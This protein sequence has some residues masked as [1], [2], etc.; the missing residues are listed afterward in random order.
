MSEPLPLRSALI[1]DA[2]E[3]ARLTEQL[4]Y[5]SQPEAIR[6]R[7]ERLTV[8]DEYFVCVATGEAGLS[9][10][11]AAEH[12][13]LLEYGDR[14]EIV[15]LVVDEAARR[16]GVGKALVAAVEAW[17]RS[18]GQRHIAVRSNIVREASHPFYER[19]GFMR[20]KTQHVYSRTL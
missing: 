5:P 1:A 7:L 12:R 6:E 17:T 8:R 2:A 3:I 15:G 18:R 13:L 9:G 10:W 20:S 14:V 19:L 11:I 16:G 4:G